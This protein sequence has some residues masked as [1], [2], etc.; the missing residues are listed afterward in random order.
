MP[1]LRWSENHKEIFKGFTASFVIGLVKNE[2]QISDHAKQD[3][4]VAGWREKRFAKGEAR[5]LE[6]FFD[7]FPPEN[8]SA[9]ERIDKAWFGFESIIANEEVSWTANAGEWKP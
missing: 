9:I 4:P 1:S 5:S 6:K 8:Y 7:V 2:E 3:R